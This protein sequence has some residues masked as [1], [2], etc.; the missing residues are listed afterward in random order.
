MMAIKLLP[1]GN[2]AHENAMMSITLEAVPDGW[3]LVSEDLE[4]PAT[5]PFVKN[6]VQDED[7][8]VISWETDQEAY[9]VPLLRNLIHYWTA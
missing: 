9:N 6:L 5:F 7:G 4:T 8:T 1:C 3:A 2:G